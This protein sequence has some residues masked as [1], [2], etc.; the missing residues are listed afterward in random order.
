M[1]KK[2]SEE[3]TVTISG[4]GVSVETTVEELGRL[5]SRIYQPQRPKPTIL[6]EQTLYVSASQMQALSL[7]SSDMPERGH[8]TGVYFG[9]DF[10]L[11][12]DGYKCIV[13][14][15]SDKL[16]HNDWFT[17]FSVPSDFASLFI[18]ASKLSG[19]NE[20]YL[21][22]IKVQERVF[23][24]QLSLPQ[25]WV[26]AAGIERPCQE[27]EFPVPTNILELEEPSMIPV[28]LID[29]DYYQDAVN[30]AFLVTTGKKPKSGDTKTLDFRE[31]ETEEGKAGLL[32]YRDKAYD[33]TIVVQGIKREAK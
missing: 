31:S 2:K 4:G 14:G 26:S 10:M 20:G 11:S 22:E 29:S 19:T 9:K 13:V 24:D 18:E 6:R 33:L 5:N 12:L 3:T 8:I 30:A 1:P 27:G 32:V 15:Y 16:S 21:H 25:L 17:P 7:F 28:S 23:S